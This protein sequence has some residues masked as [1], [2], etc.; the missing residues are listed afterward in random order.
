MHHLICGAF[1]CVVLLSDD[2]VGL[3]QKCVFARFDGCFI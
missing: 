2:F 3:N 1:S